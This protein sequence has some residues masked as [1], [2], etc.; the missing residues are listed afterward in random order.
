MIAD[1]RDRQKKRGERSREEKR[2]GGERRGEAS[3]HED[4]Q[5]AGAEM[6]K[7]VYQYIG[8]EIIRAARVDD[9]TAREANRPMKGVGSG[10]SRV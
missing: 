4:R 2:R 10:H 3:A 5:E 8:E 1:C 7:C 6:N 9:A